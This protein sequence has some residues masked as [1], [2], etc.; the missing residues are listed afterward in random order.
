MHSSVSAILTP[1]LPLQHKP[2]ANVT[3]LIRLIAQAKGAEPKSTGH[4][5]AAI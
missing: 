2:F 4:S 1:V 5:Q 3:S